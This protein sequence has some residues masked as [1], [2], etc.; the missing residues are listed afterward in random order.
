MMACDVSDV[1]ALRD[2]LRASEPGVGNTTAAVFPSEV[3]CTIMA[4]SD[5]QRYIQSQKLGPLKLSSK[6]PPRK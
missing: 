5:R 3:D 1:A 2:R 6:V 4:S